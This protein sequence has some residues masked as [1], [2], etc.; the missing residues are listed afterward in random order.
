MVEVHVDH[1]QEQRLLGGEVAVDRAGRH[2]ALP[3]DS[4]RRGCRAGPHDQLPERR[5]DPVERSAALRAVLRA[6]PRRWREVV[7]AVRPDAARI[8]DELVELLALFTGR[9]GPS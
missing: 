3:G 8:R 6:E 4:S 9:G 1:G 7:D 5:T 2:P